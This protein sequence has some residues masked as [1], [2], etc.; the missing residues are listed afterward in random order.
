LEILKNF[1]VLVTLTPPITKKIN[2]K[3]VVY[4]W[5]YHKAKDIY[6]IA[7]LPNI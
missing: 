6:C 7:A 1:V 2:A 4:Q 5:W 3:L